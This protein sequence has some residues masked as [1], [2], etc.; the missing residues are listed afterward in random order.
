MLQD[1]PVQVKFNPG[2][3]PS[4]VNS[5]NFVVQ[6]PFGQEAGQVTF[7]SSTNTATW[8]TRPPQTGEAGLPLAMESNY[9]AT[10]SG[11]TGGSYSFSFQTGPCGPVYAANYQMYDAPNALNTYFYGINNKGVVAGQYDTNTGSYGFILDN[12]QLTSLSIIA[13][14]INDNNAVVGL[15][16]NVP[17]A[18]PAPV[19]LEDAYLYANGQY[20]NVNPPQSNAPPDQNWAYGINNAGVIV[21]YYV[22]NQQGT[23]KIEKTSGFV[24]Q[25]DGTYQDIQQVPRGINNLGHIVGQT[26]N[27]SWIYVNGVYNNLVVPGCAEVTA[28]GIND[29][30]DTVGSASVCNWPNK[31]G[32]FVKRGANAYQVVIPGCVFVDAADIRNDGVIVGSCSNEKGSHGFIGTPK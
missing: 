32:S 8:V 4:T 2:M 13:Y 12:G 10:I 20:T 23:G 11:L 5:S 28:Y 30:D 6:G 3:A 14:K 21:G 16:S 25:A 17:G 18:Q 22:I 15:L 7:D 26:N 31:S 1:A 29:S 9:T 27:A 19:G 24:R